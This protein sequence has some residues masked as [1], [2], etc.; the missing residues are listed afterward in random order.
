MKKTTASLILSMFISSSVLAQNVGIGTSTPDGSAQLHIES[1]TKGLLIPRVNLSSA[2]AASPVTSPMMGLLVFNMNP[3]LPGGRG[4]YYWN[5]VAWEQLQ[6]PQGSWNTAGNALEPG[7][8]A[9][10]GSTTNIPLR[11]IMNNIKAGQIDSFNTYYGFRAGLQSFVFSKNNVA[12]GA[13]TLALNSTKSGLVAIGDSALYANGSGSPNINEGIRNTAVGD[14]SL[15]ENTYGSY[16]T[17]A[18]SQSLLRNTIGASNTAIGYAALR[19][20]T[21]GS[22]NIAIGEQAAAFGISNLDCIAIGNNALFFNKSNYNIAI[23]NGALQSFNSLSLPTVAVQN[24]AIGHQTIYSNIE[25]NLNTAVG[26][27]SLFSNE[28]GSQNVALGYGSGSANTNGS[29][30][31]FIGYRSAENAQ[32]SGK[33]YIENSGA[34]SMNA[35]IYGDFAADS[36]KLNAKV[37]I[38]DRLHVK[39]AVHIEDSS[40]VAY[41]SGLALAVASP[42]PVSG[43]GRRIMWYA[44]K[45]AF[46]A[47]YVSGG[48]WD[49]P[50]VGIYSIAMGRNAYATGAYGFAAGPDARSTETGAIAMGS[51]SLAAGVYS[52]AIGTGAYSPGALSLALGNNSHAIGNLSTS[53]GL[54]NWAYGERSFSYGDSSIARGTYST[55]LGRGTIAQSWGSM[56]V[57][58]FNDTTTFETPG[59]WNPYERLF[60]VGNGNAEN[61]RSNALVIL[62]NGNT[63]ISGYTRLGAVAEGAPRI[64]TKK[65]VVPAG[66]AVNSV[67]NIALGNGITD[68]KV[69]AVSALLTYSAATSK[70]PPSY[71]DAAG[72]EYNIQVQYNGISIINKNGNSA[73]IGGKPLTLLITYEE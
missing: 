13:N 72:Y 28:N 41:A 4:F 17:A 22:N 45:A 70:I 40:M 31:I 44:D 57:G 68:N 10:L 34:D 58:L 67:M 26:N 56:S 64:K 1:A 20:N 29:G 30:N 33:L 51:S 42:P 71:T 55:A 39:D 9:V 25:G 66:P 35:L 7:S 21:Q 65:I 36:L 14:K 16:N 52:V 2:G 54:G 47:G 15:K 62:K 19:Q 53:V 48:Q 46:R 69:L 43:A 50:N 12:V 63:D 23:G 37:I 5:G 27:Q 11:F 32:G 6:T 59:S 38:R 60:V 73:N 18:G 3:S 24:V 49:A 61:F 8:L